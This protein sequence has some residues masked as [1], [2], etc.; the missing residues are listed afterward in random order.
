M[1]GSESVRVGTNPHTWLAIA[2]A[3]VLTFGATTGASAQTVVVDGDT[4]R[5]GT[6]A[7]RLWG[8][9]APEQQQSCAGWP[10]GGEATRTLAAL[11]RDKAVSCE[12]RTQDRYGRTVAVCRADGM[13]LG[14]AMV[15]AGMAWAFVR[16]SRDYVS[17]EDS[18]RAAGLGVHGHACMP[19]WE[20]RA[21]Q[22]SR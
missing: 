6:T 22:R 5:I 21:A 1:I 4:I 2:L 17:G 18:A 7:Y 13:D 8:I 20:W 14:A 9:D 10:A 3:A 15:S 19:A 11:M 16:Y 12:P